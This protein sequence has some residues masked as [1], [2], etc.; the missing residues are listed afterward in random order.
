MGGIDEG[1]SMDVKRE[2]KDGIDEQDFA[3][4]STAARTGGSSSATF[5]LLA[6]TPPCGGKY[7]LHRPN[8]H[9]RRGV[10]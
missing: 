2:A 10:G 4:L 1:S 6:A 7:L 8:R 9:K 3:C 5:G